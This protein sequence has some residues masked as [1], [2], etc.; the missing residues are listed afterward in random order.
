MAAPLALFQ[1]DGTLDPNFGTQGVVFTNFNATNGSVANAVALEPNGQIVLAGNIN[2]GVSQFALARYNANGTLDTS[3]GT[4]GLVTTPVDGDCFA[5]GVAIDASGNI[6][7]A[8]AAGAAYS[9]RSNFALAR[10]T[11]S[12][13]LDASFGNNG[14]VE[15]NLGPTDA[16]AQGLALQ[17]DGKIVVVGHTSTSTGNFHFAVLRYNTDGTLDTSFN[18]TGEVLDNFPG[19]YIGFPGDN[20]KAV[21]IQAGG[22]IVA[23]GGFLD[24]NQQGD[25]A[26]ARYNTD[27]TPDTTFNG[28]GKVSLN[29]GRVT[30]AFAIALQ[31]NGKI[32][33]AGVGGQPG[34]L[35]VRYNADG[36][37]DTGFGTNGIVNTQVSLYGDEAHGAAQIQPDGDLVI[38]GTG[39]NGNTD[40]NFALVRYV[41]DPPIN[42]GGTGG[43]TALAGVPF[44]GSVAG[45]TTADANLTANQ[46]AATIDWG[47]NATSLG[48]VTAHPGGGFRVVGNHTYA[49]V[50]SYAASV[51]IK[52]PMATSAVCKSSIAVRE[53]SITGIKASA[54]STVFGEPVTFTAIV[55][56]GAGTSGM[57]T[58][59][60][61]FMDGATVMG[62][63]TLSGGQATFSTASLSRSGHGISAVYGGDGTFGASTSLAFGEAV[64]RA[65]TSVG[66]GSSI[67]PSVFGQK[68]TFTAVLTAQAPGAGTPTGAVNFKEGSTLL[69][70]G[71]LQVLGGVDRA[72]FATGALSVGSHTITAIYVGDS[73]FLTNSTST[74]ETVNRDSTS[75]A[76][77]ASANPL[78]FGQTVTFTASV[79]ASLP[80]SGI[81]SGTV[82][83]KDGT[84]VLGSG[85]LNSTGQAT[86]STA[87]L[88][89]GN[90]AIT[91]VYGGDSRFIGDTSAAFGEPVKSAPLAVTPRARTPAQMPALEWLLA[92]DAVDIDRYFS[93]AFPA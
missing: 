87:S 61:T 84:T 54:T 48:T 65:A 20:A 8:G 51:T 72:T 93:S 7:A 69:G 45:F 26:L 83:F 81:A 64:S 78:V 13:V 70:K 44:S 92:L 47:D 21:A 55:H 12:G 4:S 19:E 90:H 27:G 37:L 50:G 30:D 68:T 34:F 86:F 2:S 5:T 31:G 59:S 71:V 60:V 14:T 46:F 42:P 49:T 17:S 36:T 25:I 16:A 74:V 43:G 40:S 80:G 67:S 79:R 6:I 23:T 35:T 52:G 1:V 22:K 3:F 10:Y 32:V 75:S 9:G 57:P 66:A 89:V 73:N 18:S 63:G 77:R 33:V 29:L 24:S 28:S 38:A 41:G 91:A 85:T 82:I 76:V 58:G 11:S 88:T 62:S 56:P 53:A 39:A 15:T